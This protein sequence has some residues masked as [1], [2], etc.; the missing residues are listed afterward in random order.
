MDRELIAALMSGGSKSKAAQ[1]GFALVRTENGLEKVAL[2]KINLGG[3]EGKAGTARR[4][5]KGRTYRAPNG[6]RH[7]A[8]Q[9]E[10]P[11]VVSYLL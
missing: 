8:G 2:D 3:F 6:R 11:E 4:S 5:R 9:Y 10:T 1:S 7:Y